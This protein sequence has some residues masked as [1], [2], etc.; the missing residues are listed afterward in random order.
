MKVTLTLILY[1][2]AIRIPQSSQS[3]RALKVSQRRMSPVS[4]P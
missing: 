4:K 3:A 2:S 1:Q